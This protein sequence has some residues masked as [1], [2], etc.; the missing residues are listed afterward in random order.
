MDRRDFIKAAI[1]ASAT[2][3]MTTSFPAYAS[4]QKR[5]LVLGGRDF[6]G[7]N[8]VNALLK[9]GYTVT[10]FNRGFTNPD[11]FK[12]LTWIRGDREIKDGSGL[13]N[14]KAHI[15]SHRYDLVIDTW[16]KS[17]QAVLDMVR[18]LKGKI[19]HYQYVSSISVYKDRQHVGINEEYPLLDVSSVDAKA[20][21][22]HYAQRKT[23]AE[24]F[25]FEELPD[26]SSTFRSHGMRSD[27]TPARIYEPYWPVRFYRGGEILLPKQDNHVMQVCDVTSMSKFMLKSFDVGHTGAFNVAYPTN[28]F[29]DYLQQVEAV[30]RKPHQKV[31]VT[32]EFLEQQ[33]IQ[34]YRDL[35]LWRP[36]LKGFYH[37]DVSKALD[38]G[39]ENRPMTAMINDQL[40]GYFSRNPD[41]GF[42][43]GGRGTISP[44]K[45]SAVLS[46]WKKQRSALIDSAQRG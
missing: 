26:K 38:A 41:D 3:A 44:Q 16:Q 39:L 43:F 19:G 18:L 9:Q 15:R 1:T 32:P 5:A 20:D 22:L 11:L 13:A 24:L 46:L 27:R 28:D 31:W 14:L 17:P 12:E 25:L 37:I 23:L 21:N 45:E 42:L 4:A 30:T 40:K 7:P 29:S 2:V 6:F 8:I 33:D 10:L 36:Q 35:P 34:P